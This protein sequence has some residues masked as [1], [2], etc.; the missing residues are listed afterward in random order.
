MQGVPCKGII[1]SGSGIVTMGK[2]LFK[3]IAAI[4]SKYAGLLQRDT[5]G[6]DD[7]VGNGVC[8]PQEE[9]KLRNR[10]AP[11]VCGIDAEMLKEGGI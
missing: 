9:D 4:A 8:E 11:G 5:Q 10:K 2:K 1:D 7:E 3:K 6:P